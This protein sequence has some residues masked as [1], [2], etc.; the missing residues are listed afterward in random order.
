MTP[1]RSSHCPAA[2]TPE[3]A[4]RECSSTGALAAALDRMDAAIAAAVAD[5][6]D[7]MNP[8]ELAR[9]DSLMW[10]SNRARLMPRK[11]AVNSRSGRSSRSGKSEFLAAVT[12]ACAREADDGVPGEGGLPLDLFRSFDEPT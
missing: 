5:E 3:Q 9:L 10:A 1:D 8:A 6:I 2:G 12:R 7:Q 11:K 4:A